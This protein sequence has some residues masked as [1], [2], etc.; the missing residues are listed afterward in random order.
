MAD[1]E[2]ICKRILSVLTCSRKIKHEGPYTNKHQVTDF[3][4]LPN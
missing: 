3:F 4:K 1:S 2:F